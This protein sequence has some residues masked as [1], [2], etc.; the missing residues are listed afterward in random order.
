MRLTAR[1][2]HVN[3]T[4]MHATTNPQIAST[5]ATPVNPLTRPTTRAATPGD[6]VPCSD[7]AAAVG[8]P[9][10]TGVELSMPTDASFFFARTPTGEVD[11]ST[12]TGAGRIA[13]RR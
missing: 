2:A 8:T 6:A 9:D 7:R 5:R 10:A 11:A 12:P 13:P 1:P 4:T 3:I